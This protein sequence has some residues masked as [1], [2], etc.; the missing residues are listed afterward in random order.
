MMRNLSGQKIG[1]YE[2]REQLG[3]GGMAEVYKAYQP[4]L[5][6][7]VAIKVMLGH[8]ASDGDF[9]ERFRREAKAVARLRHPNILQ[10]FDFGV[11]EDVYFMVMEYIRGGTLKSY[12]QNK[13]KLP[14][15]EALTITSQ[16]ADALDYAHKADMIHRDLKPANVMF[17]D[18][19]RKQVVLTDFGIARLLGEEGLTVSG[20]M[21]GTPAYMS[22]EAGRGEDTD[23]RADLYAL[24]II[25]YE[26]LTGQVPYSA[27]TPL[28]I[29]MKH[30]NAPLPTRQDYGEHLPEPVESII[31]KSI[32]KDPDDR[33]PTAAAMKQA[34]DRALAQLNGISFELPSEKTAVAQHHEEEAT[35]IDPAAYQRKTAPPARTQQLGGFT[36][37][38]TSGRRRAMPFIVGGLITLL[39]IAGIAGF[40]FALDEGSSD[41]DAS[42][43]AVSTSNPNALA[44]ALEEDISPPNGGDNDN[45]GPPSS[46]GDQGG[47]LPNQP[48]NNQQNNQ[49]P[50]NQQGGQPPSPPD[51][52][53]RPQEGSAFPPPPSTQNVE[54]GQGLELDQLS[55]LSEIMDAVDTSFLGGRELA[56]ETVLTRRLRS[57][58]ENP[59]VLTAQAIVLADNGEIDE[60]QA[61][62]TQAVEVAP[63]NAQGYIAEGHVHLTQ[64]DDFAALEALELARE[65]EPFNPEVLWRLAVAQHRMGFQSTYRATLDDAIANSAQG[66]RFYHLVGKI[67]YYEGDYATAL[68]YLEAWQST[69]LSEPFGAQFLIGAYLQTDNHEAAL[70]FVETNIS[71]DTP[72]TLGLTAYVALQNDDFERAEQ[73]AQ[74]AEALREGN[75]LA[76]YTLSQTAAERG[77]TDQALELLSRLPPVIDDG[78]SVL[79]SSEF[80]YDVDL[81][82]A[83]ILSMTGRFT[84]ALD[85]YN[86]AEERLSYEPFFYQERALLNWSTGNV[87]Q[88]RSDFFSALRLMVQR[89]FP[90]PERNTVRQQILEITFGEAA[91]SANIRPVNMVLTA[92]RLRIQPA[93]GLSP[94]LD[95]IDA[96]LLNEQ[97]N[98]VPFMLEQR[99]AE[100]PDDIEALIARV[101]FSLWVGDPEAARADLD[102]VFELEPDSVLAHI[103]SVDYYLFWSINDAAS[104]LASAQAA[105]QLAP[106]NPEAVW[107]LGWALWSNDDPQA[108]ADAF[109][110]ARDLDA[111]GIRYA[112]QASLFWFSN[113]DV[114]HDA[115]QRALNPLQ[116]SVF[117]TQN[118]GHLEMLIALEILRDNTDMAY[119]LML[120]YAPLYDGEPQYYHAAAYAAY[121]VGDYDSAT[122]WAQLDY[123][124]EPDDAAAQYMLALIEG[125]GRGNID[126]AL[127]RF[128]NMPDDYINSLFLT[129]QFGHEPHLDEA[130]LLAQDAQFEAALE[131]YTTALDLS[132]PNDF[133]LRERADI[134]LQ[135]GNREAAI[136]DLRAAFDRTENDALKDEVLEL[137]TSLSSD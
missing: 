119:S 124:W 135:L 29:I 57:E 125:Y 103:A 102:R 76:I 101:F 74:Q 20:A 28:A 11:K 86:Q 5:D 120:Q 27:D 117:Y 89:E 122:G 25:F 81:E 105:L 50:N 39:I 34:I 71:L 63:D 55:G 129:T 97:F 110:Q 115:I 134:H 30:I 48:P 130:R 31:L 107:R 66:F 59:E 68:P 93:A 13:G 12:I 82:R 3:R 14:P 88:A 18:E 70:E 92:E 41:D 99:L 77:E 118:L 113:P 78:S 35:L 128:E 4:G 95:E 108:A 106:D 6:R 60:A 42:A 121:V 90:M 96:L 73:L 17:M 19:T 43:T 24:G 67:L 126:S 69:P 111:S 45:D 133:I 83:R 47:G 10:V 1:Q 46:Q 136:E 123:A 44:D 80:G 38:V 37:E 109:E 85:T 51:G 94:Y 116:T 132:W 75:N 84:D 98:I 64:G 54:I 33:Y 36:T 53:P 104:A 22:P 100:N 87:D 61:F 49:A 127:E 8:L 112:D 131:A 2:I 9:V 15:K 16:L 72:Q 40:I 52:P 7:F 32:T 79:L 62:A 56:G 114:R 137:L 23:E 58:P 26:M 21:V 65:L 91:S